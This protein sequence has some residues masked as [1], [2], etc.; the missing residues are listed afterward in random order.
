MVA[1]ISYRRRCPRF[2]RGPGFRLW[3]WRERFLPASCRKRRERPC[4]CRKDCWY[5]A[6]RRRRTSRLLENEGSV[7]NHSMAAL[8]AVGAGL[9][10]GVVA[11]MQPF[12]KGLA[13]VGAGVFV[14]R[15]G[16]ERV[17]TKK[18][19]AC[20]HEQPTRLK[21]TATGRPQNRAARL[22]SWRQRPW[23]RGCVP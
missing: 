16:K 22:T 4:F 7:G 1:S 10:F 8:P 17:G 18:E 20:P 14:D 5:R 19:T 13:A 23:L 11:G 9:R 2:S 3:G 6:R 12:F 15:H 21:P